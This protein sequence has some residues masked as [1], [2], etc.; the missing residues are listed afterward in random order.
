MLIC[1]NVRRNTEHPLHIWANLTCLFWAWGWWALPLK[2]LLLG[3]W[4]ILVN[5]HFITSDSSKGILAPV[6]APLKVWYM[7]TWFSGHEFGS[8]PMY[9]RIIFQNALNWPKG[10]LQHDSNFTDSASSIFV[11]KFLHSIPHFH[12][13]CLSVRILSVQQNSRRFWASKTTQKL[14]TF[15]LSCLYK[16]YFQHFEGFCWIFSLV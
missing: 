3:F 8:N 12:L 6:Q 13:F 1:L 10:N 9:V 14:V 16:T 11:H 5:Q 15:P 4:V 2:R 7:L